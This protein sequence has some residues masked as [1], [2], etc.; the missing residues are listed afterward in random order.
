[1]TN[2]YVLL[3][4]RLIGHNDKSYPMLIQDELNN[5]VCPYPYGPSMKV[6]QLAKPME[7]YRDISNGNHFSNFNK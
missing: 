3:L 7:G 1:M 6:D 4:N 5:M 2:A